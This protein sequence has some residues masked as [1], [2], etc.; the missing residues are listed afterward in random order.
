[1]SGCPQSP[2]GAESIASRASH[3]RRRNPLLYAVPVDPCGQAD[4]PTVAPFYQEALRRRTPAQ[5]LHVATRPRHQQRSGLVT[6]AAN[7]EGT[8]PLDGISGCRRDDLFLQWRP[9]HD[10]KPRPLRKKW[11][12]R[13]GP[14]NSRSSRT[15]A[16]PSCKAEPFC[17]HTLTTGDKP[18][19]PSTMLIVLGMFFNP[20]G[21]S[22][23][24]QRR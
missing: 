17:A 4:A 15:T 21:V 18:D 19:L 12:A 23:S 8:R 13:S 7:A 24:I 22:R 20:F 10:F 11:Q 1:V 5:R 9:R 14:R 2:P 16:G 6:R 3:S